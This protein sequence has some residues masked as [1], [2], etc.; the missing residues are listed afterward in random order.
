MTSHDTPRTPLQPIGI[1]G[2]PPSPYAAAAGELPTM[3]TES[4]HTSRS[5]FRP[6]MKSV[7][8]MSNPDG[9]FSGIAC[10]TASLI[11]SIR[12]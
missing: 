3:L 7:A 4:I 12:M 2:P 6:H 9:I 10:A 5:A 11:P 8:H 1:S